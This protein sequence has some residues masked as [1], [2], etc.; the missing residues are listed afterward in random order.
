MVLVEKKP[1]EMCKHCGKP[2]DRFPYMGRSLEWKH[3]DGYYTCGGRSGRAE[4]YA[5]PVQSTE[6]SQ[7]ANAPVHQIGGK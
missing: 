3:S 1:Q 4:T 2:I 7:T 5:E 6:Q